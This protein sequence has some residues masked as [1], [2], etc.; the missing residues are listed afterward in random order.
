[1]ASEADLVSENLYLDNHKNGFENPDPV[2]WDTVLEILQ[3]Y[4]KDAAVLDWTLS[5]DKTKGLL[6]T[7]WF[8]THKGEVRLKIEAV[9]WGRECRVEVWQKIGTIF[10]R[11]EKS[12]WARRFERILQGQVHERFRRRTEESNSRK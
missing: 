9:V 4:S 6:W 10:T 11:H 8:R 3:N 1:M 7:Q 5:S 2:L 12:E